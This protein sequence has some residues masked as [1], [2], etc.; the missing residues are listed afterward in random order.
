MGKIVVST[1]TTLDGVVQDPDGKEGWARGGWFEQ[2]MGDGRAEW[3]GIFVAEAMRADALLLGRRSDEWYASRWLGRTGEWADRL[4]AL[5][6]YVVSSTIGNTAW[7]NGTVITGDLAGEVAKLKD[8]IAGDIVVYGSVQLIHAIIEHDL[9]DEIRVMVMPIAVGEG[10]RLF[11][12]VGQAKSFRLT[13]SQALG[14]GTVFTTYE[15]VREV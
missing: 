7:S 14:N 1:N 3:A 5:P 6:K 12:P 2:A 11:G 4:N 9:V 13:G 8:E 10:R 15:V